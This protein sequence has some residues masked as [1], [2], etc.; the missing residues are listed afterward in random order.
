MYM[1][2]CISMY[3]H[4]HSCMSEYNILYNRGADFMNSDKDQIN[5]VTVQS[6]Y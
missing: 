2:M 3:I 5:E 6:S 4:V 1:Y